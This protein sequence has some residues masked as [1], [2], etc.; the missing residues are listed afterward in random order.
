M[1]LADYVRS[2]PDYPKQGILFRDVTTLFGDS[3]AFNF[4]VHEMAEKYKHVNLDGVAGI[5]ARG[6]IVGAP[7]A[8]ALGLSFVTVRKK[9]KL[10]A[11][12]KSKEYAL[13]YGVDQIEIHSDAVTPNDRILLVDDLIATGGTACAV[14]EL[15]RE[16]GATVEHAGFLIDLPDLGGSEL[17]RSKGISTHSLMEFAGH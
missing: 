2:V 14:A 11:V 13:E 8:V 5:E 6:F 1:N 17:L 12:V 10:P 4:A 3:R 16:M 7:L 9:G 15:L